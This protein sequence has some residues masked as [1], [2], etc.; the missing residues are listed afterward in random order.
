MV[1]A[2]FHVAPVATL[3]APAQRDATTLPPLMTPP[4]SFTPPSH[5]PRMP[6]NFSVRS[7]TDQVRMLSRFGSAW[8][9]VRCFAFLGGLSLRCSE[10]GLSLPS[11]R[12]SCMLD[13]SPDGLLE[14]Q[15]LGTV[16]WDFTMELSELSCLR[17]PLQT[18][19]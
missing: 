13:P 9:R 5:H 15:I 3:V 4:L 2:T 7:L 12:C 11:S 10:T 1:L 19:F 17:I 16:R 6:Q 8:Y 14:I 18:D